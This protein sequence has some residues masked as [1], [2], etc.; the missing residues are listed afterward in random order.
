MVV[1]TGEGFQF[2]RNAQI[3]RG[4]L[5]TLALIYDTSSWLLRI[6]LRFENN[7]LF[8]FI[9]YFYVTIRSAFKHWIV[10]YENVEATR[11]SFPRHKDDDA[12][13]EPVKSPVREFG[14]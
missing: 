8:F 1:N 9:S 6:L 3:V 13:P 11:E 14:N 12:D 10:I 2:V 7:H 4:D 5:A